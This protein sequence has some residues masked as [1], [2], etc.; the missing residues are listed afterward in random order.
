MSISGGGSGI[1]RGDQNNNYINTNF[2]AYG[3]S[4]DDY[5]TTNNN[6]NI[7]GEDGNDILEFRGGYGGAHFDGGAGVDT[8]K[9]NNS[10]LNI[11]L[12]DQNS[13]TITYSFGSGTASK[14]FSNIEQ[15]DIGNNSESIF[16]NSSYT[17]VDS[18]NSEE[19][20]YKNNPIYNQIALSNG[21]ILEFYYD[22]KSSSKNLVANLKNSQGSNIETN[23]L[24]SSTNNND[25][26]NNKFIP[27]IL[28]FNDGSSVVSWFY[29]DDSGLLSPAYQRFDEFG[30]KVGESVNLKSI[31]QNASSCMDAKIELTQGEKG[32]SFDIKVN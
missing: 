11:E 5:L 12:N 31:N 17:L 16:S 22:V 29:V 20:I 27:E 10:V 24:I 32:N 25:V 21:N 3:G 18:L 19:F 30:K 15:F 7:Y 8:L 14:S 23:I 6:V 26:V 4:G 13:G 2:E 9:I 1:V 28:T